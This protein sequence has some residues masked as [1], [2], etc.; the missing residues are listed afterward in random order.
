MQ[1]GRIVGDLLAIRFLDG[2]QIRFWI[3]RNH[4][5]VAALLD[6]EG[7]AATLVVEHVANLIARGPGTVSAG[8][9]GTRRKHAHGVVLGFDDAAFL[10]LR[11]NRLIDRAARSIVG[12]N[13]DGIGR[14]VG[15][16]PGNRGDALFRV[17]NLRD[18]AL[19]FEKRDA[20]GNF[21]A[22]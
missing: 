20:F 4:S 15:I 6:A 3:G 8:H 21:A 9:I 17:G 10:Q 19:L 2:Q 1:P 11:A 13:D 14:I 16:V 5:R 18:A 7:L 12:R 22:R